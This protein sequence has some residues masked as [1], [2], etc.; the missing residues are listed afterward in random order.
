MKISNFWYVV[1]FSVLS[2]L[3]VGV[4]M[5]LNFS[6]LSV[7][8]YSFENYNL[9]KKVDGELVND[10]KI[11]STVFTAGQSDD[12]KS[13]VLSAVNLNTGT[14]LWKKTLV[15]LGFQGNGKRAIVLTNNNDLYIIS[16]QEIVS[17]GCEEGNCAGIE[18]RMRESAGGDVNYVFRINPETGDVV[19]KKQYLSK[20]EF[21]SFDTEIPKVYFENNYLKFFAY[22]GDTEP[23]PKYEFSFD[24]TNGTMIKKN[25][26]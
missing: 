8:N 24:L 14:K 19:W 3:V 17:F 21:V 10:A 11:S 6:K 16:I 2:A 25:I 23:A 13:L 7:V 18:E 15:E 12:G 26:E 4:M 1:I 20:S 22:G 5:F 9:S